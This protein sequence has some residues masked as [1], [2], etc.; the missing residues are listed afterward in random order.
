[1]PS[2]DA[3]VPH[4]VPSAIGEQVPCLPATAHERQAPHDADPQQKP[5]VQAPLM[6]SP[7]AAQVAPLGLRFVHELPWQV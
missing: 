3:A 4:T 7:A 1:L 5:S 6:H 2:Q